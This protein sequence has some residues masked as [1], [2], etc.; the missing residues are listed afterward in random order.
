MTPLN[1]DLLAAFDTFD[2]WLAQR[3][4]LLR[5]SSKYDLYIV[6]MFTAE[7]ARALDRFM[8]TR[9]R[10]ARRSGYAF[11]SRFASEILAGKYY[12]ETTLLYASRETRKVIDGQHRIIAFIK[13]SETN[14]DLVW[15]DV[16][17]KVVREE[18]AVALDRGRHRTMADNAKFLTGSQVDQTVIR[19]LGWIHAGTPRTEVL[20]PESEEFSAMLASPD[21]SVLNAFA[22]R[23]RFKPIGFIAA[24]A[25]C[26][27]ASPEKADAFFDAVSREEFM[28][29][30]A[31]STSAHTLSKTLRRSTKGG[32][33]RNPQRFEVTAR[34]IQ[35]FNAWASG[36]E[37]TMSRYSDKDP[38]PAPFGG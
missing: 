16:L 13:A 31:A 21:L 29:G 14:P 25:I 15:R 3:A 30:G 1:L 34:S 20:I 26:R 22:R 18:S 17:V 27:S 37:I 35:A 6:P 2:D 33:H 5:A 12:D 28:I 4:S 23:S 32:G 8:D 11:I 38:M 10:N 9:Q 19:A 7:D 24:Y 36:R